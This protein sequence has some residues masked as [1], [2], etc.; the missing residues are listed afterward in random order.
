MIALGCVQPKGRQGCAASLGNLIQSMQST[1]SVLIAD[2]QP[3][4]AVLNWTSFLLLQKD[5][6][7]CFHL[8]W[9]VHLKSKADMWKKYNFIWF[10]ISPLF[11]P[12]FES[13]AFQN[14]NSRKPK[15]VM[16]YTSSYSATVKMEHLGMK[17]IATLKMIASEQL[18]MLGNCSLQGFCCEAMVFWSQNTMLAPGMRAF[19]KCWTTCKAPDDLYL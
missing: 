13:K 17:A 7:T 10:C 1:G 14:L 3:S 2:N 11:V 18:K 16:I 4:I 5:I 8:K 9:I 12:T 15:G 6:K 19:R